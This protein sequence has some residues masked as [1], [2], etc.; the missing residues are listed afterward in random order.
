MGLYYD[1]VI[2]Q[3]SVFYISAGSTEEGDPAFY[4]H[5]VSSF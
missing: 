5:S 2:L 3:G 1:A 4:A